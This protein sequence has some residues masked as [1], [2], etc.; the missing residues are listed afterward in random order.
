MIPVY[1]SGKLGGGTPWGKGGSR[2]VCSEKGFL[3]CQTFQWPIVKNRAFS[4]ATR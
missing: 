1:S 4:E 3:Q 2:E